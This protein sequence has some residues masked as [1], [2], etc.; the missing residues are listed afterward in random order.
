[1]TVKECKKKYKTRRTFW[2]WLFGYCPC[3]KRWFKYSVKTER[4]A[5][6]FEEPSANWLTAC[7]A[8][9]DEDDDYYKERWRELW[10]SIL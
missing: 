6:M 4:R 2:Q 10:S 9:H 3:C 1:M 8:C 5:T 7:K